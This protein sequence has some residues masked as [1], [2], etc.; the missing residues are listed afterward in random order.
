M[1]NNLSIGTIWQDERTSKYFE[2]V[3]HSKEN[4]RLQ[5][6]TVDGEQSFNCMTEA[7]LRKHYKLIALSMKQFRPETI[8]PVQKSVKEVS[9]IKKQRIIKHPGIKTDDL[10]S[11]FGDRTNKDGVTYR[12]L[13]LS[14]KDNVFR[15]FKVRLPLLKIAGI[16]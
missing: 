1:S 3:A 13:Y 2:L 5:L 8:V 14:N 4:N 15:Y 9:I 7:S 11:Q 12:E 16:S 6:S 10:I